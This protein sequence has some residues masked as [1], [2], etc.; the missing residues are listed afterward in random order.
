MRKPSVDVSVF[1]ER[2]DK[3]KDIAPGCA[4]LLPAAEELHWLPYR[5]ESNM[6]YLTGYD[7]PGS[8]ALI[9]P[10][11]DPEF[12]MFVLPKDPA[13]EIWDGYRYGQKGVVDEFGADKG[14]L[15]SEFEKDAVDLLIDCDKLY[16]AFGQNAEMDRMVKNL[17]DTTM[18]A[19]GRTG[20]T[21]IPIFDPNDVLG[22]MRV[23]KSEYEQ[24]CLRES[25]ELTAQAHI[26]AMK[27]TEPGVTERQVLGVLMKRFYGENALR[28]GYHSIVASGA[29]ACTLHYRFNDAVCNKGDL[30]LIDAG[31]EKNYYTADIT[32]TF[33][34]DG[35]YTGPQKEIYE[36]VLKT[37]KALID[38]LKVGMPYTEIQNQ[39]IDGLTES[40][41]DLGLLKGSKLELIESGAFRK[42]Y[43][44]NIGHFL[45]MDV[46]DV[47]LYMK[48]S[49]SRPLEAGM[50]FTIEPGIYVPV[51]DK[52]APEE[53][54][55]I[56]VRIEDDILLTESGA[57]VMTKSVPKEVSEVEATCKS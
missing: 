16:F 27:F 38:N 52:S 9:R 20:K 31:A 26:D 25:C 18:R 43:P 19:R 8:V 7:E 10:G 54:R 24:N 45:G 17:L 6:Y 14:A 48:G 1:K 40:L 51:D 22:E 35:T 12:T 37:Q 50:A 42:Y 11:M 13:M 34:V 2:R 33:P 53:F 41:I 44:H 23:V 55:G 47:G 49:E 39:A 46:H 30:L 28:E 5:Q 21:R 36:A 3:L 56:G 4:F 15:V 29:N 32:R 57:E